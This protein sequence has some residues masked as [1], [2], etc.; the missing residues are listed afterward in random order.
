MDALG[1]GFLFNSNQADETSSYGAQLTYALDAMSFTGQ[2]G[3]FSPNAGGSGTGYVV[4][5]A[6]TLPGG[7]GLALE[8]Y[9]A[10]ATLNGGTPNPYS[11]LYGEFNTPLSENVTLTFDVTS[12]DNGSGVDAVTDWEGKIGITL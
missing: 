1:L 6:Y 5:V 9:G 4:K 8:Y 12:T 10:D 11:K 2:Y 3:G 7:S